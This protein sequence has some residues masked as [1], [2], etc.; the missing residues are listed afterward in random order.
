M[1][2]L[3]L[4]GAP[5]GGMPDRADEGG[6][7]GHVSIAPLNPD[8]SVNLPLLAS[9]AES[10]KRALAEPDYKHQ[11]TQLVLDAVVDSRQLG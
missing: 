9:W 1:I 6:T 7:V 5:L 4:L 3:D 11:L 8:G 10:R 2:D